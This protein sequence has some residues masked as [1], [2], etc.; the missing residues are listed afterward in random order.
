MSEIVESDH[1]HSHSR[2]VNL[3]SHYLKEQ[4]GMDSS[5]RRRKESSSRMTIVYGGQVMVLDDFPPDKAME[6]M[7]LASDW[8]RTHSAPNDLGLSP[9]LPLARKASLARFLEKRKERITAR[10]AAAAASEYESP[11]KPS[12]D[13]VN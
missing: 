10:A 4:K 1:K 7:M 2:T 13:L 6:I 5:S 9:D 8:V 12:M 3:L 11:S